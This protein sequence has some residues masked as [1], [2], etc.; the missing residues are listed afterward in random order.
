MIGT[1][2]SLA[3]DVSYFVY[4]QQFTLVN[5]YQSEITVS[6]RVQWTFCSLIPLL[7]E[8]SYIYHLSADKTLQLLV[9]F[10]TCSADLSVYLQNFSRIMV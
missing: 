2:V 8:Q 5:I 1:C 4:F 6:F 10:I 3:G 9:F 7:L